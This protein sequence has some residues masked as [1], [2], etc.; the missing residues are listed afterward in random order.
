MRYGLPAFRMRGRLHEYVPFMIFDF[1]HKNAR[2]YH[3]GHK[4]IKA[5]AT[6]IYVWCPTMCQEEKNRDPL[7]TP[8]IN[9]ALCCGG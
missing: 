9:I 3:A 2:P 7:V 5:V 8:G 1:D 4:C 6:Q